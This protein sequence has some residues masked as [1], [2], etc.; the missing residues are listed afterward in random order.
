AG[1]ELSPAPLTIEHVLPKNPGAEWA[2]VVKA[3]PSIV[4][5]CAFRMGNMCLTSDAANQKAGGKSFEAKR[6][7]FET[8]KLITTRA[9]AKHDRWD[10]KNIEYHQ[11]YLAK[12]AAQAWRFP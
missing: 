6:K 2:A 9:V 1:K 5:D 3:D 7:V 8:S 11:L 10:R 12:L 4:D